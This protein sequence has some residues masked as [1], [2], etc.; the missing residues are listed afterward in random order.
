MAGTDINITG[1]NRKNL[2]PEL[3]R[4]AAKPRPTRAGTG[5]YTI[6]TAFA[7]Q[8]TIAHLPNG[9]PPDLA[10]RLALPRMA[11]MAGPGGPGGR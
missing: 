10:V 6:A 5:L 8:G 1:L 9:D 3:G 11:K 4:F 7:R 2:R